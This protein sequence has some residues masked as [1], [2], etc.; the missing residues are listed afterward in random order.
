MAGFIDVAKEVGLSPVVTPDG[1]KVSTNDSFEQLWLAILDKLKTG[2]SVAIRG[3]GTFNAKLLKGRKLQSPLL[4]GGVGEFSD[5]LVIRFHASP[6]AKA[7][8]N[9]AEKKAAKKGEKAE[10]PAAKEAPA[11]KAPPPAKAAKKTA[12]PAKGAKK[13]KPAP[14]EDE[15]DVDAEDPAA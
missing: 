15:E 14:V 4:A 8:I 5:R 6:Q 10:K 9:R 3:F 13:A 2:E 11:K 1:E 12:P 7:Y